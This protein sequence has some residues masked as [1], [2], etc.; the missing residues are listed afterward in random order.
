MSKPGFLPLTIV[1]S[2]NFVLS[3]VWKQNG[4]PV[5]LS[6]YSA[7]LI[8]GD[9]RPLVHT[10]YTAFTS[11]YAGQT[12]SDIVLPSTLGDPTIITI[13]QSVVGVFSFSYNANGIAVYDM[14]FVDGSGNPYTLFWGTMDLWQG[15]SNS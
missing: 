12:N 6:G 10:Y 3:F 2:E 7:R 5:N 11:N 14:K 1:Q 15:V 9:A 8:I 4:Q 13:P